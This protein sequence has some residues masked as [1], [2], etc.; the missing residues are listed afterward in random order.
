MVA[1]VT[2]ATTHCAVEDTGPMA[3]TE[4]FPQRLSLLSITSCFTRQITKFLHM[5]KF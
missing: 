4:E 2:A 1:M 3:S 5:R